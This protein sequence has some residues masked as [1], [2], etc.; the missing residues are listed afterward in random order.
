MPS[1]SANRNPVNW[2]NL[3]LKH[4]A[5]PF[6][7]N[8]MDRCEEYDRLESRVEEALAQLARVTTL[9]LELFRSRNFPHVSRVDKELENM[10]GEKERA[11]GAL[12]QHLKE[13]NCQRSGSF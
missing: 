8:I 7:L 3:A 13:H 10:V 4:L 11:I 9:Q 12:R 1:E 6:Y 5:L 2:R